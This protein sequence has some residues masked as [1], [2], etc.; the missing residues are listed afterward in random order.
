MAESGHRDGHPM[1]IGRV[2]ALAV[3][4]AGDE[5]AC[6]YSALPTSPGPETSSSLS[7]S[8]T[9][10]AQ[11]FAPTSHGFTPAN[12]APLMPKLPPVAGQ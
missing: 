3:G 5:R 12:A 9:V 2:N 10:P 8:N 11:E 7:Q 1:A 4:R 6:E